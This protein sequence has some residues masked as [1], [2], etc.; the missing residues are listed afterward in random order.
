MLTSGGGGLLIGV[1]GLAELMQAL[2]SH[3]GIATDSDAEMLRHF[4]KVSG[5]RAGFELCAEEFTEFVSGAALKAWK[6]DGSKWR[7]HD[8]DVLAAVQKGI[9]RDAVGIE[10]FFR[11]RGDFFEIVEGNDAQQ[12]GWVRGVDPEKIIQLPQPGCEFGLG[13]NPTA[14]KAAEAVG[15]G[16]AAGNDEV[17]AEIKRG[18]DGPVKTHAEINLVDQDVGANF[19]SN[20]ADF[21]QRFLVGECAGGI[22]KVGK[23]DEARFWSDSGFQLRDVDLK[24]VFA[25]PIKA[26]N[27]CAKVGRHFEKWRVGGPFNQHVIAGTEKTGHHQVIGHGGSGS[28]HY[29]RDSVL[30]FWARRSRKGP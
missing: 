30:N 19:F 25:R 2:A 24:V 23:D 29:A 5:N 11:A 14:A 10:K 20:F 12:F 6:D 17:F 13:E 27:I 4:E 1:E 18:F 28:G 26:Q 21:T 9:E 8:I 7:A 16:K 22:V 15:F 3:F